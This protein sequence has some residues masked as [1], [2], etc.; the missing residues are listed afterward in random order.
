MAAGQTPM[1]TT[2][3]DKQSGPREGACPHCGAA[4]LWSYGGSDRAE[5]Q[6]IC[7]DCGRFGLSREEFDLRETEIVVEDM[8]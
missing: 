3:I 7:P 1:S 6:V 4:A 8:D 5:V 2:W